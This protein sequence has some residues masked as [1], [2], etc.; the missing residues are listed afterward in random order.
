[1]EIREYRVSA[2][3][4]ENEKSLAGFMERNILKNKIELTWLK[5]ASL[6]VRLFRIVFFQ[7]WFVFST[8]TKYRD[9][10]FPKSLLDNVAL[11]IS[12]AWTSAGDGVCYL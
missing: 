7:V 9:R 11:R 10:V 12:F 4:A 3:Q 5:C 6:L 8:W 2:C 1:M